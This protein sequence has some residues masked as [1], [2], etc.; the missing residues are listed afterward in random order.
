VSES[1]EIGDDRSSFDLFFFRNDAPTAMPAGR[2]GITAAI[3]VAARPTVAAVECRVEIDCSVD[4]SSRPEPLRDTIESRAR[5]RRATA[6]RA[7]PGDRTT[8]L[9]RIVAGRPRVSRLS[10]RVIDLRQYR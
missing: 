9:S 6:A 5:S 3:A 7:G 2:S 4:V 1:H 10:V 8:P